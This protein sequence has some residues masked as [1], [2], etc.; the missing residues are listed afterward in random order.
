MTKQ[1]KHERTPRCMPYDF[2]LATDSAASAPN[3]QAQALIEAIKAWRRT[4]GWT[5]DAIAEELNE[6]GVPTKSGRSRRACQVV[7]KT[8]KRCSAT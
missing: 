3:A 7:G 2:D 1:V 4:G 6:L 5:P 8:L